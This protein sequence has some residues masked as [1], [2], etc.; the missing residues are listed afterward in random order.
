V[1]GDVE[2]DTQVLEGRLRQ[3]VTLFDDT[4]RL[5]T[6]IQSLHGQQAGGA[7]PDIPSVQ[8]FA[9][10]YGQAIEQAE[11][12]IAAIRTAIDACRQAL[13]DS[14]Q[15]LQQQDGA[16]QDQFRQLAARLDAPSSASVPSTSTSTGDPVRPGRGL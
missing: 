6:Q 5:K 8:A 3:L 4:E 11:N 1:A 14:A 9:Q 10:R 12:R 16:I 15:S 13:S 7:W 2:L